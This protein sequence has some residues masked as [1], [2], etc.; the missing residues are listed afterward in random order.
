VTLQLILGPMFSGKTSELIRRLERASIAGKR[1]V[2]LRPKTD[3]RGHLTHDN[4]AFLFPIH[5]VNGIFE[6][7][8]SKGDVIGV[9]EAQFFDYPQFAAEVDH[10]AQKCTVIAC[11]LNGTSERTPF[12]PIQSLIPL[13]DSI[14]ML[15]AI[16]TKCGSEMGTFSYFK[17][18]NKEGDVEVGGKDK[19]TT[20]CRTC[21]LN[22]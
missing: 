1:V 7:E 2:L 5:F 22:G 4:K 21:Y 20:L 19:Y 16:C 15:T 6:I 14:D 18:G 17:A 12:A 13:C 8:H 10:L 9:D 11:G 3:T